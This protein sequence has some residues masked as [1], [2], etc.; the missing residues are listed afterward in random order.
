MKL[1]ALTIIAAIVS[2]L[3]VSS[4]SDK[5]CHEGEYGLS[6]SLTWEDE[7]DASTPINDVIIWVYKADGAFVS[8]YHFKDSKEA[9]STL[10]QLE[11]GEYKV[12]GATN[13]TSPY[14]AE[15][16]DKSFGSLIMRL[17][18]SSG[19]IAQAHYGVTT[20]TVTPTKLV[21]ANVKLCRVLSELN[22]VIEGA[23]AG[24]KLSTTVTSCADGVMPAIADANGHYGVATDGTPLH[25]SFPG[26]N[27]NNGTL[28]DY[29]C[30]MPTSST[31]TNTYISFVLTLADGS[32]FKFKA[33]APVMVTGGKYI[34][35]MKYADLRPFMSI[36]VHNISD[37]TQGWI[38]NGEILNP[39]NQSEL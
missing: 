14:V 10:L 34:L 23:P 12:I 13:F 26:T 22:I 5:E 4:C 17:S 6:V 36:S 30:L 32:A 18:I 15:D 21:R 20:A 29:M 38:I 33:E 3:A 2:L 24:S 28:S 16:A 7:T 1:K 25:F 9:A 19:N 37:W 8:Q 27:E 39:D 35:N 31:L 11:A